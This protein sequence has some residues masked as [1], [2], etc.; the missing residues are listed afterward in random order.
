MYAN[1]K[2][3]SYRELLVWQK[4]IALARETYIFCNGLPPLEKYGLISQLERC[5]V[6]VPSNI[7]EGYDR[8]NTKEFIQ[9]LG[10]ALGSSAE[11]ETQLIIC[12][13]VYPNLSQNEVR[14]VLTEVRKMLKALIN[15]LKTQ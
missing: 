5:A 6:S 11:L 9:F 2:L 7:A 8:N 10:I 12:E 4:S 15:K 3:Q 13:S 14:P 1:G